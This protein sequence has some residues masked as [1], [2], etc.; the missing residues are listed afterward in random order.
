MKTGFI[1]LLFIIITTLPTL[2][3]SGNT[4]GPWGIDISKKSGFTSL[5]TAKNSPGTANKTMIISTV[6]D[7]NNLTIPANRAVDV[8]MGGKIRYSGNLVIN[9]PFN[10]GLYQALEKV[11]SGTVTGL[12]VTRPEWFGAVGDGMTNNTAA[13]QAAANS[14]QPFGTLIISTAPAA[15]MSDEITIGVAGTTV[16]GAGLVKLRPATLYQNKSLFAVFAGTKGVTFEGLNLDGTG[17]T[18]YGLGDV[19]GQGLI[20]IGAQDNSTVT[21]N[22]KIIN[23]T[24]ASGGISAWFA[25][26]SIVSGNTVNEAGIMFLA[27]STHNTIIGNNVTTLVPILSAGGIQFSDTVGGASHNIIEGNNIKGSVGITLFAPGAGTSSNHYSSVTGNTIR[28][29][30]TYTDSFGVS[31]CNTKYVTVNNNII[32]RDTFFSNY[33]IEIAGSPFVVA[34][35]NYIENFGFALYLNGSSSI[36]TAVHHGTISNNTLVGFHVGIGFYQAVSDIAVSGNTMYFTDATGNAINGSY[37]IANPLWSKNITF[38]GN[39]ITYHETT[40]A[41]TPNII[42]ANFAN[43][44]F[45]N[46]AVTWDS[47]GSP[48]AFFVA[49]PNESLA[50]NNNIVASSVAGSGFG[51]CLNSDTGHGHNISNNTWN[52]INRGVD[53]Y[54]GQPLY[55]VNITNNIGYNTTNPDNLPNTM[56]MPVYAIYA[57]NA[58]AVIGG[59]AV[60]RQYITPTGALMVRY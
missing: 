22:T 49:I 7:C 2:A 48:C 30:G 44:L 55:S 38:T 60:G 45:S 50:I 53:F 17:T 54:G 1:A 15:F 31:L 8:K 12:K 56:T 4:S 42:V 52:G 28:I 37:E 18:F 46:N 40:P 20:R 57:D 59:I 5:S 47:T 11:G 41:S 35:G 43:S 6:M 39:K 58:A 3:A 13:I 16:T 25:K 24:L 21:E 10:A 36:F 32:T 26:N 34:T 51:V 29:I 19:Y 33:G 23:C 27:T 14:L 9:G